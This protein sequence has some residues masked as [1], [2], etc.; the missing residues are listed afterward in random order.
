[1]K[2]SK[3]L[4]KRVQ[5][6]LKELEFDPKECLWDCHGTW[7][8]LHRFIEIAGAKHGI[9]YTLE[10]VETNSER[11]C[12]A[13]KCEAWVPKKDDLGSESTVVTYGE[14]SPK[15]NKN[16]YPYAMA[17]KRAVDRAILKLLGLHGFIYSEEEL[18][19]SQF[20]DEDKDKGK[21]HPVQ[22]TYEALSDED[23][24]TCKQLANSVTDLMAEGR[25]QDALN[26]VANIANDLKEGVKHLLFLYTGDN[27]ISNRLKRL[28]QENSL[29]QI[30]DT[31]TD[32][33]TR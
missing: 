23:Q 26:R 32:F 4:D 33:Q 3:P 13:I 24:E 28:R 12:V 30:P 27:K 6:I 18:D 10:E 15:N 8:M 19:S 25:E 7:V 2:M 22:E 31:S 1:M 21:H 9:R 11:G 20:K 29:K 5:K 14:A 17:E 16:A